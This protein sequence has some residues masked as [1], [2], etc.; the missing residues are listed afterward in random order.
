MIQE[1]SNTR[2]FNITVEV[3][4]DKL[5]EAYTGSHPASP[6]VEDAGAELDTD[7]IPMLEHELSWTSASGIQVLT[8]HLLEEEN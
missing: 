3:D 8:T 4:V 1:Q 6:S 7:L 5:T 2:K